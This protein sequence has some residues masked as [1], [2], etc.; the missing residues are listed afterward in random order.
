MSRSTH[1]TTLVAHGGLPSHVTI[2]PQ[3]H[4][5]PIHSSDPCRPYRTKFIKLH[6]QYGFINGSSGY[7][8]HTRIHFSSSEYS[9]RS[10]TTPPSNTVETRP[11]PKRR[12]L[13]PPA[14]ETT[15]PVPAPDPDDE[16]DSDLVQIGCAK[17][18]TCGSRHSLSLSLESSCM[19]RVKMVPHIQF[20]L[21][22]ATELGPRLTTNNWWDT[23]RALD[24]ALHGSPLANVSVIPLRVA[25]H[26]GC[27]KRTPNQIWSLRMTPTRLPWT[28]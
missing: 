24:P 23:S 18:G 12:C 22:R 8:N 3:P 10:T 26:D 11:H 2:N 14:S 21:L 4:F 25:A 9:S 17:C 27:S 7:L 28:V 16:T 20:P 15:A 5:R 13:R 19:H 1:S 6:D